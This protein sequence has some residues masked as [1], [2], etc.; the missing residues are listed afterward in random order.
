MI[1]RLGKLQFQPKYIL[2][3]G[4]RSWRS[5]VS[6]LALVCLVIGWKGDGA[7]CGR[8]TSTCQHLLSLGHLICPSRRPR[9]PSSSPAHGRLSRG[10][11]SSAVAQQ[12][13]WCGKFPVLSVQQRQDLCLEGQ[14]LF[15]RLLSNRQESCCS[16][17]PLIP[18]KSLNGYKINPITRP[19]LKFVCATISPCEL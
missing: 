10:L 9:A 18:W 6:C 11:A 12:I 15:P 5:P 13:P 1:K 7:A 4:L 17:E 8:V 14:R 16:P 19:I 2:V 3:L